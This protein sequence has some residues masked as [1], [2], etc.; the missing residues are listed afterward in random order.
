[1]IVSDEKI[2]NPLIEITDLTKSY[3]L[4][5]QSFTVLKGLSLHVEMGDFLAVMGPSGSGKSTLL[6]I[7]G[8]LD[9]LNEGRYVLGGMN[10]SHASDDALSGIRS[11]MIGFVFQSFNLIHHMTVYDNVGMPFLY[12][13][14][15]PETIRKKTLAAIED[16]GLSHRIRHKPVELSGGEMQRVAI[17]RALVNDPRLILADEPTGNLD[18]TTGAMIMDMIDRQ[19]QKGTTIILVTH[20]PAVASR[21]NHT[22]M[23]QDG[24]FI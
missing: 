19:N 11:R 16:V 15:D 4:G 5:S 12:A 17:A 10:V 21:A 14:S 24:K 20:D 23:L 6:N 13:A 2:L 3:T 1:M 18:S 8:C 22:V 9:R 7:I